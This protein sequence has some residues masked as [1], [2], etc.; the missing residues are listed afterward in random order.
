MG[1]QPHLAEQAVDTQAHGAGELVDVVLKEAPPLAVQGLA[2]VA[3]GTAVLSDGDAQVQE[4]LVVLG[5]QQLPTDPSLGLRGS[6]NLTG[7]PRPQP[8]NTLLEA[9][10]P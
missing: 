5:A 9:P 4:P 1:P 2:V 10:N 7:A 6:E 8:P 3:K